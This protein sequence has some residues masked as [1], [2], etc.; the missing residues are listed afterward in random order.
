MQEAFKI[1]IGIVVL[2]FGIP[3]GNFLAKMTREEL[4]SGQIW[5]KIIII[6]SIVGAVLALV[7][8]DDVLLFTLPFIAIVTSR[9]LVKKKTKPKKPSRKK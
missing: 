7:F 8:R 2:A 5:F 3:I 6:F 9:S 1:I 4:K